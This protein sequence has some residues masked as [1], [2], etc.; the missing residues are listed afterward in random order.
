MANSEDKKLAIDVIARVDK[1]EKAMA[2][3]SATTKTQ[4]GRMEKSVASMR[5]RMDKDFT[6]IGSAIAS[7]VAAPLL[8]LGAAGIIRAVGDVARGMAE[9]GDEAKR[10]GVGVEAFQELKYVAEQSRVG[11]DALTDGLKEMNLRADEFIVSGKGSSAEAF[12]RLGYDAETLAE[13]LHDP[14]ALFTEIIGK[15]GQLDQAA[16]IRVADEVFGGTGGEQFVQ[17]IAQGEQGIRDTIDR[18][19]RGTHPDDGGTE[20]PGRPHPRL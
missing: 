8:A 3:A 9:I 5:T 19:G 17:L 1:L 14:S 7:R 11:I 6:A 12:Q 4:T 15:L 10:A 20:F 18:A 2:K 16:Q 13:K